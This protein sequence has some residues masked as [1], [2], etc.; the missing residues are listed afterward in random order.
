MKCIVCEGKGMIAQENGIYLNPCRFCSAT[1]TIPKSDFRFNACVEYR[2]QLLKDEAVV[3]KEKL[4]ANALA[5]LT[6]EEI[7]ALDLP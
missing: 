4:R 7:Q 1:G 5:K 3:R 6:Y 2:I